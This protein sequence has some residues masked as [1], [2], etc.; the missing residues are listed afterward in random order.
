MMNYTIIGG[1]EIEKSFSV[2]SQLDFL[3]RFTAEERIAIRSSTDPVI[4]DFMHLLSLESE[5]NLKDEFIIKNV[6]YLE[7]NSL[8]D[9]G[10][11]EAIL[12]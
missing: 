6:S 10:R 5:V 7:T 11:A 2:L 4:V 8:L 12:V 1:P 3:K 9:S